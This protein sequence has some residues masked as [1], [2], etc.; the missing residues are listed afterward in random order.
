VASR[1]QV[2]LSKANLILYIM[3]DMNEEEYRRDQPDYLD[4]A[5]ARPSRLKS[6]RK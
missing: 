1:L 3:S 6:S 2:P 4:L 5:W